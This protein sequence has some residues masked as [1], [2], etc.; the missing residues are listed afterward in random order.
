SSRS[1]QIE[2]GSDVDYF[3]VQVGASGTLTVYTT[4]SLDTQ[5]TLEN[6]SG[7]RLASDDDEGSN[8]NFR[9]EHSVS[10]GTYYIKVEG[11][12]SSST[13]S[14]TIHAS[15][16]S[17]GGDDSGGGNT[18][19]T[20]PSYTDLENA[21][22][23]EAQFQA[24]LARATRC[25][26]GLEFPRDTFCVDAHPTR[27]IVAHLSD[28][29][30]LVLTGNTHIQAGRNIHLGWLSFELRGNIRVLTTFN[31]SGSAKLIAGDPDSPEQVR[32]QGSLSPSSA[33][34]NQKRFVE[35][36]QGGE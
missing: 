28:G 30:G 14:Y 3:S 17:S 20:D 27:V 13:G 26:A 8:T 4:G 34:L 1:G 11:Y 5:G 36:L 22:N 16:S 19:K 10:A 32:M 35:Q 23:N 6:S 12:N 25:R 2:T 31:I 7:S 29:A 24:L 15:V 18:V 33:L 9:I 21:S